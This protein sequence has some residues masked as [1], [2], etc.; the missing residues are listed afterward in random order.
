MSGLTRGAMIGAMAALAQSGIGAVAAVGNNLFVQ[1]R[2]IHA[3]D[4]QTKSLLNTGDSPW[5]YRNGPGWSVA[6]V[7]R[8]A[9]KHLNQRR[10]KRQC[11]KARR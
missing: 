6:Q 8:M 2:Q 7:K 5:G 1:P 4:Y 11:R 10:H 3:G 9:K